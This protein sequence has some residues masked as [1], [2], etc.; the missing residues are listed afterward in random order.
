MA[1]FIDIGYKTKITSAGINEKII[2]ILGKNGII[3]GLNAVPGTG[4]SISITAGSDAESVC[5]IDGAKIRETA[6][7]TNIVIQP[8]SSGS[9][10]TDTLYAYYVHGQ[11]DG[12]SVQIPCSYA[13]AQNTTSVPSTVYACKIA[14]I[15]VP[16][17]AASI[18]Q[19][20]I[21]MERKI[22]SLKILDDMLAAHILSTTDH[23]NA[24]QVQTA[25]CQ[26][27]IRQNLIT[28]KFMINM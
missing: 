2:D 17:G 5:Y 16:N 7:I 24:H 14:E 10:R 15:D 8:N 27:K 13:V 23:K 26:K 11:L 18:L 22:F 20:N 28:F 19:V 21:R 4:L 25:L 3:K 12:N 6:D 1:Q 9:T